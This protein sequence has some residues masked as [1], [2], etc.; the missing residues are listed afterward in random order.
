MSK[1]CDLKGNQKIFLLHLNKVA[2]CCKAYPIDIEHQSVDYYL[3]LW[4]NEKEQLA[5]GVELPGCNYCWQAENNGQTSHRQQTVGDDFN[6]VEIFVSNLCNQMCS[7]CSPKFSSTWEN[8]IQQFG[9]F[10]NVS[11]TVKDNLNTVKIH[12]DQDQW[13]DKLKDLISRG[14][15]KIKLLGGEP[16]MQRRNLQKLLELNTNQVT[17]LV[18]TTNL[19]PT[20]NK[21]L[22]WVLATFPGD[23]L[24]FSISLDT[25]PEYNAVPRAGFDKTKFL[26]NLDLLKQHDVTFGFLSV[27]SV[28]NIFSI[29]DYQAWLT[30]HNYKG[31]FF[32]INNPDCLSPSYLPDQFKDLIRKDVLPFDAQ[33]LLDHTPS[34]VDLKRFEQYNYLTQYFQRTNTVVSDQRLVNYLEWLKGNYEDRNRK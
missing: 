30:S 24:Q 32:P 10:T 8:S 29:A 26:E 31:E 15:V 20:N 28:L 27:I 5:Q 25:V 7:Y 19:S 3:G 16:L 22:K 21:F 4:K 14:P 6:Q 17:K 18:I 33:Q 11:Q 1:S 13:I 9:N 23:K 34:N 12:A 2:S